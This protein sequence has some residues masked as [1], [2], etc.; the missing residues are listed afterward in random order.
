MFG[1]WIIKFD[2]LARVFSI[3]SILTTLV[4]PPLA[5]VDDDLRGALVQRVEVVAV[6]HVQAPVRELVDAPQAVHQFPEKKD[7]LYETPFT[8]Q[9]DHGGHKNLLPLT[10]FGLFS[11]P[12]WAIGSNP[13]GIHTKPE[14]KG[15][16]TDQNGH[17]EVKLICFHDLDVVS[18]C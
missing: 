18:G 1:F 6:L 13:P 4:L 3:A 16:F 11:H 7:F 2:S 17:P 5:E 14:S 8:V 15:G 10:L 12:A 9:G